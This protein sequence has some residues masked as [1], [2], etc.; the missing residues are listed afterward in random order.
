[1]DDLQ[2]IG[3][4]D[5]IERQAYGFQPE[6]RRLG[7][8]IGEQ[9]LLPAGA[10]R[11][12][13]EKQQRVLDGTAADV[14]ASLCGISVT[15]RPLGL[16]DMEDVKAEPEPGLEPDSS[17]PGTPW[18]RASTPTDFSTV[19]R[20]GRQR[21]ALPGL[22]S[23]QTQDGGDG[24][25]T[26]LRRYLPTLTEPENQKVAGGRLR[27]LSNWPEQ[28]GSDPSGYVWMTEEKQRED[29][30]RRQKMQEEDAR[31]QRAERRRAALFPS[32]PSAQPQSS[33]PG[34]F[35]SSQPREVFSQSSA[36]VFSSQV[37]SQ[38]TPGLFGSRTPSARKKAKG[39]HKERP[40]GFR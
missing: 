14:Y 6:I 18:R 29:E 16:L 31:R 3:D 23:A 11:E 25:V 13:Y 19:F 22:E 35:S 32:R 15:P 17:Q 10:P 12:F 21:S 33:Q 40:E 39:K 37:M 5:I 27:L 24:A 1:M 4:V 34:A 9:A 8:S 20:S 36:P 7:D 26:R 38:V 28:P 2:A 30:Q